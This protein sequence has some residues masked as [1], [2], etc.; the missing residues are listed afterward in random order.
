MPGYV[1]LNLLVWAVCISGESTAQLCDP[2]P[3]DSDLLQ[4]LQPKLGP[5][6]K[7]L[8]LSSGSKCG[9]TEDK[10]DDETPSSSPP[11]SISVASI[12]AEIATH[13]NLH[14]L[15]DKEHCGHGNPS[16]LKVRIAGGREAGLGTFPWMALIGYSLIGV[17]GQRGPTK[18]LCGGSLI[19][20]LYVLTAAHC[21]SESDIPQG[22]IPISVRLGEYNQSMA[23]D[24]EGNICAPPPQDVAIAEIII[25]ENFDKNSTKEN[26]IALIRLEKRVELGR[27]VSP[28][29]LPR[30]EKIQNMTGMTLT[31]AGWGTTTAREPTPSPVLLKV[32]VP[33][34]NRQRCNDVYK[35]SLGGDVDDGRFC[36][37]GEVGKDSCQGDSGGP[38]MLGRKRSEGQDEG[39]STYVSPVYQVGVVSMGPGDCDSSIYPGLYTN[40]FYFMSWVLRH[41]RK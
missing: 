17:G 27:F 13:P 12:S 5:D 31:V 9:P 38:L 4:L 16:L 19:N 29:C 25:H 34:Q 11:S 20:E 8:T 32:D 23:I 26:D 7:I 2:T 22:N 10:S 3:I 36:V 24:C 37:G 21:V 30:G 6:A 18:F 39:G 14:L 41:L 15:P 40:V 35:T 1:V 33:F 28:I